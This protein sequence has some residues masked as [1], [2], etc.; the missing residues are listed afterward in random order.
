MNLNELKLIVLDVDGTLTDGGIYYTD[1]NVE[2]KEFCTKDAAGIFVAK[3]LGIKF[4]VITGRISKST[5][6][7]LSELK[8]DYIHQHVLD[9]KEFLFNF[10]TEHQ[11]KKQNLCYIGDDLN[12]IG[13]MSC[14]GYVGCP[15]DS[16]FEVKQIADY[17]SSVEG[18]R[19]AVRDVIE[20]LLRSFG[21]WDEG[22]KK[23]YNF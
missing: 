13:A 19:G 6:K 10:M 8:V 4:M 20:H 23:V 2:I 22:V 9:K 17:V 21:R 16:C 1:N 12:D 11:L 7:R 18:G 15:K 14:V 3:A 5:E